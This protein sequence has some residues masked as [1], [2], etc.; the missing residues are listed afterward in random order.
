MLIINEQNIY[1]LLGSRSTDNW[2]DQTIQDIL[3]YVYLD[4]VTFLEDKS[5]DD[6]RTVKLM[7]ASSYFSLDHLV[8]ECESSLKKSKDRYL[9]PP[10]SIPV[11]TATALEI[12]SKNFKPNLESTSKRSILRIKSKTQLGSSASYM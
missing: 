2:S 5:Y 11:L 6:L 4:R 7:S 8:T 12:S 3:D 9:L 10:D 1:D